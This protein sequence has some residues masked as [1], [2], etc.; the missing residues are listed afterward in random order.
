M[1]PEDVQDNDLD[2][3]ADGRFFVAADSSDREQDPV[4]SLHDTEEETGEEERYSHTDL[5]DFQGNVEG[6]AAALEALKPVIQARQPELQTAIDTTYTAL[7]S[8][9]TSHRGATGEY[10]VYTALTPDQVKALSV[11]LDA[12]SEQVARVPAVVATS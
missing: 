10:V 7:W 9:L 12:F 8:A 6:S 11:A 3:S 4:R 2:E 5:W 1:S